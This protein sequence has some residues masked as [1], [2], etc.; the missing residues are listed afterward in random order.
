M[1]R[2]VT[3]DAHER[4]HTHMKRVREITATEENFRLEPMA[5]IAGCTAVMPRREPVEPAPVGT[6]VAMIWSATV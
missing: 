6:I 4:R 2:G 5:S 1:D 3:A